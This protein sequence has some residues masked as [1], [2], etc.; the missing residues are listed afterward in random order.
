MA[1]NSI[2]IIDNYISIESANLT[3]TV[4]G[5]TG[6]GIEKVYDGL[7]HTSYKVSSLNGTV[8][9]KLN[10]NEILPLV[11]CVVID[12]V[13]RIV[14][15]NVNVTIDSG[16]GAT[17]RFNKEMVL[18]EGPNLIRFTETII[19]DGADDFVLQIITNYAQDLNI[20]N[21][22]LGKGREVISAPQKPFDPLRETYTLRRHEGDT[23]FVNVNS[24]Q[25]SKRLLELNYTNIFSDDYTVF[26]D[27][28]DRCWRKAQPFYFCFRPDTKPLEGGTYYFDQDEF[29]YGYQE[30]SHRSVSIRALG[31][32]SP[33]RTVAAEYGYLR[34][35]VLFDATNDYCTLGADL[36]I[37]TVFSI[38]CWAS[39][40]DLSQQ[41][42][43]LT[44]DNGVYSFDTT[45]FAGPTRKLTLVVPG[46]NSAIS[47][48]ISLSATTKYHFVVTRSGL[49]V[50]FYIDGVYQGANDQEMS[51]NNGF[52]VDTVG[53][54][55]GTPL[56]M[57]GK[58]S[59]VR[60]YNRVLTETEI[61]EL[62]NGG[63]AK[64]FLKNI[65]IRS[66]EMREG[67][68]TT[69]D[70]EVLPADTSRRLTFAGGGS[71][72]TWNPFP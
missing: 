16:P 46:S 14:C 11:D 54:R 69:V 6:Y 1:D 56:G 41:S 44:S 25:K 3:T 51:V 58:L 35:A 59:L 72:P 7:H 36:S 62:Y 64:E 67:G 57:N 31:D 26:R 50:K 17:T 4:A 42:Y 27:L 49:T 24:V 23:G 45:L 15:T 10:T 33:D 29:N 40:T 70:D 39:L 32:I 38:E 12:C 13:D 19:Q 18:E 37:G 71:A 55:Q 53:G 60:I 34:R 5:D 2:F 66:W 47:S 68:G 21:L 8:Q 9:I 28:R 20:R 63:N 48:A 52:E 65:C 43:F 61:T 22:I 30:G